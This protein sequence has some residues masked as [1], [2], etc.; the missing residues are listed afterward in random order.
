MTSLLNNVLNAMQQVILEP[1]DDKVDSFRLVGGACQWS[2]ELFPLSNNQQ[3]FSID[4]NIPFLQDFLIDAKVIWNDTKNNRVR[5]GFWTEAITSNKALHLEALAIKQEKHNLLIIKNQTEEFTFRQSTMQ[6]AREL[7]L[8]ND[9]LIEQNEYLHTRILAI[10]NK[11]S[12]KYDIITA[13]TTAIENA[14]FAVLIAK[15]DFTTII[16]NTAALNLFEQ[17]P[18]FTKQQSDPMDVIVQLLKNQLPEYERIISTKST[19]DG[20]LCWMSPPSTLKWLKIALYP[21]LDDLKNVKN[22]I[23]FANDIS[24]IKHLVQRNKKLALQDM[25][26]ELPNRIAFWQTLEKQISSGTPFYLL[27]VDINDFRCHNEFYGHEEGD[28]LL[29]EVSGRIK[30]TIKASDFIARVGGDEFAIILTD[31][32]NQ[33]CCE[34]VVDRIFDRT[35]KV[36]KTRELE[37]FNVNLSIGAANFPYDASSVEELMKFVDLSAY[38]GKKSKANSLQFYSQSIK[39]ASRLLIEVEHELREAIKNK[40]FELFL[41]PI[42]D[43]ERNE[44]VKAEALIRWNHPTKGMLFPDSFI[45]VAERSGL[46]ITIGKWVIDNACQMVEK[47]VNMG[48]KVKISMNLSPAQVFDENLFPHLHACIKHYKIDPGLLELEITEGVLIDDYAITE[49]LLNKVRAIGVSVAIDDFGT[50]YSSLSYLKK[51]PL[52]FLKIDRSF[53]RDI[54]SDDNDKAI[55]RAVIAMAHNL[56]LGV[57]AEGVETKEQLDF[58]SKNSCN[59][60]QGYLFSKPIEFSAFVMLLNHKNKYFES[61]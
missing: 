34:G 42:I 27:Y 52:D 1:V 3:I 57:I 6:S 37:S 8:H 54:V 38:N 9:H 10:F 56:N 61:S 50:G 32:D 16:A 55:V 44:I 19:W 4:D 17:D 41:Q 45:S 40:E 30:S 12:E 5:S 49:K 22:W 58:L 48:H 36:F 2:N 14:G 11:P 20:E 21:V 39:D 35:R 28:K 43:L 24:D 18:L 15:R 7:S 60:V 46:I 59:S 53:V 26:T 31:I 29:V 23:V 25:L 51:L 13:L 47:M 33:T